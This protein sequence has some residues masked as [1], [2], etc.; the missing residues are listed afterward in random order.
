MKFL[1]N[2]YGDLFFPRKTIKK[3]QELQLTD[4]DIYDVYLGGDPM[5]APNGNTFMVKKYNWYEIG[6][7]YTARGNGEYNVIAVWKKERR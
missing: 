5:K 1:S 3:M 6:F 4:K 2:K 7:F